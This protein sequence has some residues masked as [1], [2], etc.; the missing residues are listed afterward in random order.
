LSSRFPH[1]GVPP[2]KLPGLILPLYLPTLL[3]MVGQYMTVPVLP[4]LARDLGA[5]LGLTGLVVAMQGVG[6]LA[7]DLPAGTLVSLLGRLPLMLA[8][9]AVMVLAAAGAGLVRSVSLLA[10]LVLMLGGAQVLWVIAIQVHLRQLLPGHRRG[11]ALSLIGGTVRIG[12][13]AGPILGGVLAGAFGLQSA[14]FGQAAISL[15]ALVLLLPGLKAWRAGTPTNR[16]KGREAEVRRRAPAGF[17]R[18]LAR[19]RAAFLGPGLVVIA[20]QL[21]RKGRQTLLPLWG[22]AIHLDVAAIGLVIGLSSAIELALVYPA[23]HLMDHRGRKWAMVPCLLL[24]SAGLALMPLAR[25]FVSLLLVGLLAG[26]GNG[27]G[28]G[29]VLTLGTDL[30]PSRSPGRFLGAWRFI[31]DTGTA[32]GPLLVGGLAELLSLGAA[33]VLVAV[34]G[35]AGA[36]LMGFRVKETLKL[37]DG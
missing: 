30:A 8:G 35:L 13:F 10:L 37:P 7:F 22:S 32:A 23:G 12:A 2:T 36:W 29:I 28:S 11:R 21:L 20:L 16:P 9:S 24:L 14:Y 34:A 5:S 27:L 19:N 26:V 33:S 17:L 1:P 4:L 25:D 18:V 6:A 3:I 31:G 15:V